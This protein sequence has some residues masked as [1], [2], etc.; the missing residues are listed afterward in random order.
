M[1]LHF[2]VMS[3][4]LFPQAVYFLYGTR[5]CLVQECK[6]LDKRIEVRWT[7]ARDEALC[8][9]CFKLIKR[10]RVTVS[11]FHIKLSLWM[12]IGCPVTS[13][14][15]RETISYLLYCAANLLKGPDT[16]CITHRNCSPKK[17]RLSF[18][19]FSVL[20]DCKQRMYI[21]R[22]FPVLPSR[23]ISFWWDM[24]RKFQNTNM[25][26]YFRNNYLHTGFESFCHRWESSA[27]LRLVRVS[28]RRAQ[29]RCAG[30][31]FFIRSRTVCWMGA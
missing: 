22:L 16:K 11:H 4:F 13:A 12:W 15:G 24:K 31:Q 9:F 17:R 18:K 30:I 29:R 7:C 20:F 6:D 23:S 28:C 10:I 21:S 25:W 2:V 26:I 19:L 8:K 5:D 1:Q 14:G 3:T 27:H